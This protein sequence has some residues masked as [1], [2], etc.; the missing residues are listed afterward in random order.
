MGSLWVRLESLTYGLRR[1]R[2]PSELRLALRLLQDV[3]GGGR[4]R[5]SLRIEPLFQRQPFGQEFS[6]RFDPG[7]QVVAKGIDVVFLHGSIAIALLKARQ[8]SQQ[9]HVHDRP[10][11][12]LRRRSSR[13]VFPRLV[14][15]H[16]FNFLVLQN[17]TLGHR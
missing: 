15:M 10:A 2:L 13:S 5:C 11:Q 12:A 8:T 3:H 1:E 9:L 7:G 14:P 17:A 4:D 16:R 6:S